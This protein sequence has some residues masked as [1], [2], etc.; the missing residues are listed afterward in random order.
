MRRRMRR[1]HQKRI[2]RK[3]RELHAHMRMGSS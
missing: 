1:C 3:R 2:P